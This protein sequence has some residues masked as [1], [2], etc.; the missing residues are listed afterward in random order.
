MPNWKKVILSGSSAQL[1]HITASGNITTDGLISASGAGS[2]V[3]T[4]IIA[5]KNSA[6]QPSQIRLDGHPNGLDGALNSFAINS[7]SSYQGGNPWFS[8]Q[9]GYELILNNADSHELGDSYTESGSFILSQGS[10]KPAG[11]QM[12]TGLADKLFEVHW[13]GN[14]TASGNISA[15]NI[16][17]G[18]PTS[19]AWGTDLEGSYFNNFNSNTDVSEI[20]RFI[21]G[22]MSHSLDVSDASPNTQ[23]W[24]TLSTSHTEGST[25]SKSS[26]LDGVLG[27]TYENARLSNSWTGS[28]FIDLSETGSYRAVQD[29]LELK[30]WVQSSDRGTNDNDVGTNPFHGS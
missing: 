19:N 13:T 1:N 28:A 27:S 26:L 23:Y 25:T 29:Y 11:A 4:N 30:G 8:S 22:A 6:T 21:A 9:N 16:N 10:A 24:S 7:P 15:S 17:A 2:S 14:V 20:L 3:F 5:D 18:T 12:G